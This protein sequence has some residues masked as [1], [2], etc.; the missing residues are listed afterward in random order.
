M[1]PEEPKRT[2]VHAQRKFAQGAGGA[3]PHVSPLKE[4]RSRP[5]VDN[6]SSGSSTASGPSFPTQ[7]GAV[8]KTED[9]LTSLCLRGTDALPPE[10]DFFNH[11]TTTQGHESSEESF[12]DQ[13]DVSKDPEVDKNGVAKKSTPRRLAKE[14][15]AK[16]E[17]AAVAPTLKKKESDSKLAREDKKSR[18]VRSGSQDSAGSSPERKVEPRTTRSQVDQQSKLNTKSTPKK[19][20]KE[21]KAALNTSNRESRALARQQQK[22][23]SSDESSSEHEQGGGRESQQLQKSE[24]EAD[25]DEEASSRES[26]RRPNSRRSEEVKGRGKDTLSRL[27]VRE[28]RS[29][30]RDSNGSKESLSMPRQ[31]RGSK[32]A[33]KSFVPEAVKTEEIIKEK[34]EPES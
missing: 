20:S 3:S 23:D 32:E 12:S 25:A 18:K 16:K 13:D 7:K 22:P 28:G 4:V 26:S 21:K 29:T 6:G 15:K 11:A 8:P 31:G 9:F 17:I 1:G 27:K 5:K 33:S 34:I 30:S 2:R 24:S 19:G 14:G 10:L